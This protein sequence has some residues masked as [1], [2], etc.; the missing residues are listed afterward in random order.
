MPKEAWLSDDEKDEIRQVVKDQKL[1]GYTDAEASEIAGK[2]LHEKYGRR[3]KISTQT[4]KEIKWKEADRNEI[5]NQITVYATK[6]F[7]A[8]Y[9]QWMQETILIKQGLLRK[10]QFE[11]SKPLEQQNSHVIDKLARGIRESIILHSSLGLGSPMLL[12][13]KNAIDK[14]LADEFL[15]KRITKGNQESRE[16]SNEDYSTGRFAA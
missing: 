6:G 3:E 10:F 8:E 4:Y 5:T 11:I 15:P 2:L 9:L 1:F 12:Q 16:D 13:M 7:L 14:G